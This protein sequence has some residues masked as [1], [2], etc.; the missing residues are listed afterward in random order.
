MF[1]LMH[2]LTLGCETDKPDDTVQPIDTAQGSD[3]EEP[4]DEEEPSNEEEPPVDE[5]GDGLTVDDGDCDDTNPAIPGEELCDEL[6]NDCDGTV[7]ED[8]TDAL[9]WYE[10]QDND[11]Y[12]DAASVQMAC[13]Q[14]EGFTD[15]NTDCDD[16]NADIFPDAED[17]WYDGVDSNCDGEDD[18]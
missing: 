5:D 7:D 4:S 3:P 10:D 9:S 12:G 13:T 6:D 15:N 1:L 17:E 8:A 14:P 2:I 16:D 11:S 18:T